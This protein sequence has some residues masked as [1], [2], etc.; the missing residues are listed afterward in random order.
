MNNTEKYSDKDWEKLASQ[1]SGET[2]EI[3][4][5]S[6]R[7]LNDDPF[8]T[9][10][11]W[12]EMAKTGKNIRIDVDKAWNNIYS[13]LDE[14]GLLA[15]TI[16]IE[17]RFSNRILMR[18]AA[19]ALVIIG[20]GAT[21]LYLNRTSATSGEI[22][23]AANTDQRNLEVSLPD[24][25]KVFLNRNSEISYN[26]NL[27]QTTRNLTLKGE[28]FFEIKRDPSMPFII[29]AGNASVKVLGTSFSVLT[30]NAGNAVEVF[31]KTGSVMV[32]DNSGRQNL[33]LEPGFIGTMNSNSSSK[34]VNE[35]QNY[36]SWN[37]E[38]LVFE[39]KPLSVVF[40]DL[41]KVFGIDI[42][43]SDPDILNLPLTATFEKEPQDTIIHV[44]C[45]TFTGVYKKEGSVYRLSKK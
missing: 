17:S 45:S 37:T 38:L 14:N 34:V 40:N 32:S 39:K 33:I 13:K 44:I 21:M 36:L 7:L 5:E 2:N 29:D 1:F 25:S 43:T 10:K 15:K 20:V 31:V 42:V 3:P 16:R 8:N 28:A 22:I 4:G 11:K 35:D 41:K 12:I 19:A 24:G 27:G 6:E 18:I 26:K 30:N 23:V 9:E